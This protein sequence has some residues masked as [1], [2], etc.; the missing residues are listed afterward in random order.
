MT[1][2][3]RPFQDGVG[4]GG[5]YSAIEWHKVL[6]TLG[7]A[8]GANVGV[9]PGILNELAVTSSGATNIT[10][11][12]GRALP[13]GI[14]YENDASKALVTADPGGAGTTGRRCVL[15]VDY[16]ARTVRLA[17][18]SSAQDVTTI[19]A[20]TQ[21]AGVTWEIP[22]ASFQ[23]ATGGGA[24]SELTDQR[25]FTV[26]AIAALSYPS[27]ATVTRWGMPGWYYTVMQ[28][29]S[30]DIAADIIHFTPIL[31]QEVRTFDRIGTRVTTLA[32]GE[33]TRLGIYNARRDADGLRPTSLI[34]DSGLLSVAVAGPTD[35]EAVISEELVPGYYFL[36][37]VTESAT[38]RFQS[39]DSANAVG[40]PVT[41]RAS[42][43]N[44]AADDVVLLTTVDA[45]ADYV[46]NGLP[47]PAIAVTSI[48]SAF[49]ACV[50][51]RDS[52]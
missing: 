34:V 31:V 19:P 10:V 2:L 13:Q 6:E 50:N 28:T 52:S 17:I 14:L 45:G 24:I 21:I 32:A 4:D 29:A 30:T 46:N 8:V 27:R 41:G 15:E 3:S 16:A 9:V 37:Q 44:L 20:L 1:E 12:T 7:L 40:P 49:K 38:P 22:L 35:V 43:S 47:D 39:P 25:E 36:A 23:I 51:L 42:S 48:D 33:N 5:P 18:I 26:S 11:N